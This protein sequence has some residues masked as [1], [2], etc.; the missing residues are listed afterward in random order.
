[1]HRCKHCLARSRLPHEV[2]KTL[3][4]SRRVLTRHDVLALFLRR[5][6]SQ[7]RMVVLHRPAH[8]GD[9]V[10]LVRLLLSRQRKALRRVLVLR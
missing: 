10:P 9:A 3:A 6:N 2:L 7:L 4:C 8:G 5:R 1:M